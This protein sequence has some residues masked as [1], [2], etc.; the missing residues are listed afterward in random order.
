V[1]LVSSQTYV[2]TETVRGTIFR[3]LNSYVTV[4]QYTFQV[5]EPS[6]LVE[7]D[8]LSMETPD[9]RTFTDVNRDCDSAF[10]DS[11]IFLFYRNPATSALVLVAFNDDEGDDNS[12]YY[13]RGRRDGSLSTQDSYMVR[14]LTAG[15]YVLAVGRFP[16]T[17]LSARAGKSTDSVNSFSPYSCQMRRASYGNY[18][19]TIRVQSASPRGIITRYANSYVGNSCA[20]SA[21][22]AQCTYRLPGN[23]RSAIMTKCPYDRTV[24]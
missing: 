3:T 24:V 12:A 9:N 6:A 2:V 7:F 22:T 8:I 14:R 21:L 23:Y 18:Q 1:A 13:G 16:L 17:S 5:T 11:Q 19:L 4:D 10:I 15:T 20:S